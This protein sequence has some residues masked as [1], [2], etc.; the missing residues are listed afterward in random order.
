MSDEHQPI[1]EPIYE[2]EL[3]AL[4]SGAYIYNSELY[5]EVYARA[6]S[7]LPGDLIRILFTEDVDAQRVFEAFSAANERGLRLILSIRTEDPR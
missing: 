1:H 4:H 5:A 2:V 6:K 7:H 3:S